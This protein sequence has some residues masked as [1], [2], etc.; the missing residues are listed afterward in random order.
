M[1]AVGYG[2]ADHGPNVAPALRRLLAQI[3]AIWPNRLRVSDGTLPSAEHHIAN[4]TSDHERGDALDIT[5]DSRTTLVQLPNGRLQFAG[6]GPNLDDLADLLFQD[7]RTHYVIWNRR[8]A[9]R[10][11]AHGAWRPYTNPGNPHTRHMH[12]SIYPEM[13]NDVS[14]WPNG[15]ATGWEAQEVTS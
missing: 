10:E 6:L 13:R 4:P 11:R 9:T 5:N 14:D 12:L 15:L 1:S 7:S 3:D 8:I 2:I